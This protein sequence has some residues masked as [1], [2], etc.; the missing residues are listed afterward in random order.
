MPRS[1]NILTGKADTTENEFGHDPAANTIKL[2]KKYTEFVIQEQSDG[3]QT[4]S[5]QE[6]AKK[7]YPD[8]RILKPS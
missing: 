1:S 6:W 7:N 8:V 5:F 4:E 2:R 3:K